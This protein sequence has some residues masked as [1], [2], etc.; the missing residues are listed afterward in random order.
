MESLNALLNGFSIALTLTNI[1]YCLIGCL[2]GTL[3]GVLPGIG[4]AAAIA[5]LFPTAMRINP[6]G[7]M[8]MLAGIYYGAQYGGS[9]TSILL[10]IPG[11]ATSVVT[12][13]DGYQMARNGRAGPALGISAF[14]SF[15]GGTLAIMGLVLLAP[16]L[17]NAAL[18]FGPP[19][20]FSL[21]VMCMTMV[22]YLSKGSFIKALMMVPLGLILATVGMD[23]HTGTF[24]FTYGTLTLKDGLG[25]V[26]IVMG[27]FGISEV[28][29]NVGTPIQRTFL[30]TKIKDLFPSLQDW[31]DSKFP[32]LR[33]TLLGF[34]VGALP[35]MG[36]SATFLSY[37]FEKKVSKHPEKFGAGTIEGVA[38][39]E[40]CNNASSQAAFIPMLSLGIPTNVI[41]A[42]LLG[43]LMV[44]GI[45]PGP[46]LLRDHPDLFWG[47]ISSMYIGNVMLLVLNLPLIPVWVQILR[48][49]YSYLFPAILIF[50]IIGSYSLNNNIGDV[51][52]MA[53]FGVVGYL[54]KRFDF[55]AAPLV[56]ALILGPLLEDNLR[57]A[58][59]IS[60]GSFKIF[61]TRPISASFMIV[62]I[63]I[64]ASSLLRLRP[65]VKV[66]EV[67]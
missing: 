36:L 6:I 55:E 65:K 35:G 24:R 7:A 21:T 59:L 2:L 11:E 15:I 3:V 64:L 52:V 66:E 18:K 5:L 1:I 63:L 41:M 54:M 37:A 38:A 53:V 17:A 58:L 46:L 47:L 57:Q 20:F 16:L 30:K 40:T 49:P 61:F 48:I 39:P 4:P 26:P 45:T 9:T 19:E 27:L 29:I 42:M 32:I 8:I 23:P 12:C 50:C 22:T 14:G 10:N 51:I 13:L 62:S 67:S 34:I 56:L 28:M 25:I 60:K 33:G 43:A 44:Y 31:K